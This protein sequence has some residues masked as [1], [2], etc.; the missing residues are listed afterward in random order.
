MSNP[1]VLFAEDGYIPIKKWEYE[2]LSRD[3]ER[4]HCI[5]SLA[6]NPDILFDRDMV[7]T[8]CGIVHEKENNEEVK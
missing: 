6:A 2:E 5:E 4:L 1:M 7:L 3:S 8:I